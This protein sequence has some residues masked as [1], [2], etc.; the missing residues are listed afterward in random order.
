MTN[1]TSDPIRFKGVKGRKVEAI[2]SGQTITSDGGGMLL[3][4]AD[5][6]IGML[7]RAGRCF[8]DV[9]RKASCE[10]SIENLLRQR[11]YALALGYE[12]LN[13]HDKLRHDPVLQTAVGR[14]VDMA[15][16]STLCPFENSVD[17]KSLWALSSVFVEV[18]IE[19][20]KKAPDEI[21]LDFDATDAG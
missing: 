14:D 11:V 19:S 5:E 17:A 6:A 13:D 12:D 1:C 2:F 20:H 3:Q 16:S 10:H 8:T 7:S 4:A 15:S 18:F 21:I 9:R